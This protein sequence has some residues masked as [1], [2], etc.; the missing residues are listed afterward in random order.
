MTAALRQGEPPEWFTGG[1]HPRRRKPLSEDG[2]KVLLRISGGA[3]FTPTEL[4]ETTTCPSRVL[5]LL[6][7]RGYA[8]RQNH[9]DPHWRESPLYEY[10]ITFAG[11]QALTREEDRNG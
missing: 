8:E 10:R 9:V 6:F 2:R 4:A 5:R 7:L 1:D 3:W 11:V